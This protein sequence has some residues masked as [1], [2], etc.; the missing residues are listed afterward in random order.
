MNFF[1]QQELAR[2]NSQRLIVL[3]VLAIVAIVIAVNAA[4][5]LLYQFFV[6]PTAARGI[7]AQLPHG[8]Y[9]TNTIV[10]VGLILGGTWLEMSRLK[11]GGSA[12]AQRI[13]ARAVDPA[14]RDALDRRLLN[15]VE[16]MAIAS[17]VPVPRVFVM[18]NEATINAFAAGHSIDDAVVTVTRGTLTRLN[19]DELQGVVAHEFSHILNGDM[20]LNLRLIGVL[21]GLLIVA[22]AGRFLFEIG[23]RSRG[24]SDRSSGGAIM[25]L[26][27][28]GLLLWLLGYIGVFFGRLI[29]AGVSRSVNTWP[30]RSAVQF[31]AIRTARAAR[32]ARSP[33]CHWSPLGRA[34]IIRRPNRCRTC[35]SAPRGRTSRA[36]CSRRIRRWKRGCVAFTGARWKRWRRRKIWLHLRSGTFR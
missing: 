11:A 9:F 14:T 33:D 27:A 20:K 7:G 26:F 23:G 10:V 2:R 31:T 30:T 4:A 15:V 36:G 3:F 35:S 1:E 13:G 19:R 12:V 24:G 5:T 22:L 8:F 6:L 21:Y 18:D 16:E 28:A 25:V 17:G 29:K 34:S 32:C